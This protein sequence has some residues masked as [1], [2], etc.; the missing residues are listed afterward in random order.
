MKRTASLLATVLIATGITAFWLWF[1][2][3]RSVRLAGLAAAPNNPEQ[4]YASSVA[5][6][7]VSNNAG[8]SWA[9]IAI[10]NANRKS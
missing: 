1:A 10:D 6:N 7:F 2:G 3:D 8:Q 9:M 4:I 5:G